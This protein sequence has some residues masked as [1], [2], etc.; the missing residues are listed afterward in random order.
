MRGQWARRSLYPHPVLI[1]DSGYGKPVRKRALHRSCT[2]KNQERCSAATKRSTQPVRHC[3][4][5]PPLT[6]RAVMTT[7]SG[8]THRPGLGSE[9]LHQPKV[10]ARWRVGEVVPGVNKPNPRVALQL[11][12]CDMI[13]EQ[14]E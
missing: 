13:V 2:G 5:S 11:D 4:Q 3:R 6:R 10:A 8:K 14:D 7:Q 9:A 1:G 12:N